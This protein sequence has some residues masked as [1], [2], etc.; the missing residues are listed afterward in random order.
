MRKAD[1]AVERRV[2]AAM[3]KAKINVLAITVLVK[4]NAVTLVG[5]VPEAAQI[6]RAGDVAKRSPVV[7]TVD[8]R[9]IQGD[10]HQ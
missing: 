8:N 7:A 9:L 5:S 3:T 10:K 4:G 6:D 1:R 2:L